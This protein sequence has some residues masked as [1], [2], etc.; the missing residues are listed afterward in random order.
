MLACLCWFLLYVFLLFMMVALGGW[1]L[2]AIAH[3]VP[4]LGIFFEDKEG[5]IKC[6]R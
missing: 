3:L 4:V 1:W 5:F 2:V 6:S